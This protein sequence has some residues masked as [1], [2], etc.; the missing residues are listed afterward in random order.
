MSAGSVDKTLADGPA[1][2]PSGGALVTWLVDE[3]GREIVSGALQPGDKLNEPQLSLKYGVSRA[4]L[5]EAI[6]RLEGRRLVVRQPN[7]GARV[8][9]P[10]AGEFIQLFHVRE[11]LEGI[12]ARLAAECIGT[13]ELR[14]LDAICVAQ[15]SESLAEEVSLELDMSFHHL[16]ARASGSALL[17]SI[18]CEEFY[19]FYKVMRRRYPML[20]ERQRA[21]MLQH[22]GIRDAL[23]SGDR[24]LAEF[25]MRRHVKGAREAFEL[26]VQTNEA[27]AQGT[28]MHASDDP[29]GF[30]RR[31]FGS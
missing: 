12:A 31:R 13:S 29:L 3:L 16:I 17:A 1:P 8:A 19:V 21:A 15:T 27:A 18:L 11:G 9:M 30:P 7:R 28:K 24:E 26:A 23:A 20:R 4:P 6:S 25:L 10:E 5:R 22:V 2:F 14:A